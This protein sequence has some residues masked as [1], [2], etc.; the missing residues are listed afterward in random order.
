MVFGD[1]QKKTMNYVKEYNKNGFCIIDDFLPLENYRKIVESFNNS[2]FVEVNFRK[3]QRY[4]RWKKFAN[5]YFPTEDEIYTNYFWSS[6]D[7]VNSDNYKKIFYKN[8]RPLFEELHSDVG[9]FRHQATKIKNNGQNHIR[10]HYDDY[11]GYTGYILF[12]TELVWKYD[13]GGQLQIV[14]DG[15][16]KTILPAPNKLILI[17]HSTK[18]A[19]CVNP[20]NVWAKEDRNN[21]N[22]FC[23]KS[24]QKLPD[25]WENRDDYAIY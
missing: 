1:K 3:K 21:I 23:I 14:S 6:N 9:M 15:E 25:T 22:G 4:G 16:V 11:M 7:I 13:W 20:V 18:M 8:I 10:C 5:E 12:F 19:H 17:N 24:D 2:K